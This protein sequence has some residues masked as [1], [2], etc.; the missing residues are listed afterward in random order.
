MS[1][2]SANTQGKVN[3]R[4][5]APLATVLRTKL[6]QPQ[7]YWFLGHFLTLYHYFRYSLSF[8]QASIRHQ[9][10]SVLF[11]VFITYGIVLYQFYK[12]GQLK[13]STVKSQLRT[14]DN[15][16][17]FVMTFVLWCCKNSKIISTA[18]LSPVI[19]ALFHSLNYFKENLLPALPLQPAMK[20]LLTTRIA[21][22]IANYNEQCLMIA[23][24]S[25]FITL[26]QVIVLLPIDFFWLLIRFNIQNLLKFVAVATY[27]W[28]FKLRYVQS[29]Q[30]K[31]I[32]DQYDLKA[33]QLFQQNAPQLSVQW[34]KLKQLLIRF[35]RLIPV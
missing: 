30:M 35:F 17:Y 24:N 23:Q 31:A 19:F 1:N 33:D 28:F 16:Q 26:V 4:P 22:F 9:Y 27:L 3:S 32:I 18:T 5:V 29:P 14:L 8:K 12:S 13:P 6:K 10:G 2:P 34:Q 20:N 7:F 25:E 11:Y 21:F 15:L